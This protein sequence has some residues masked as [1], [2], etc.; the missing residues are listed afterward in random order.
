M[1]NKW[2]WKVCDPTLRWVLLGVFMALGW[3][4]A[5]LLAV[6]GCIWLFRV[7]Q[8]ASRWLAGL[9]RSVVRFASGA[10]R[11]IAFRLEMRW[12]LRAARKKQAAVARVVEAPKVDPLEDA[13]SQYEALCKRLAGIPFDDEEK[14]SL[15]HAAEV[16]LLS[17]V[18]EQL[19]AIS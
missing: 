11:S 6:D 4:I 8:A 12:A 7:L 19:D 9:L 5:L 13:Q 18:K 17:V 1:F 16:R 14:R 10:V 3:P 15:L 2:L